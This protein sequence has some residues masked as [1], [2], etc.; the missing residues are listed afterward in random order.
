VL[1]PHPVRA[2][3]AEGREVASHRVRRTIRRSLEHGRARIGLIAGSV[4]ALMAGS[5]TRS[6]AVVPVR[7]QA[8]ATLLRRQPLA[9]GC[10]SVWVASPSATRPRQ[11]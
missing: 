8:G 6:L 3:S 4:S 10:R 11:G 2:R 5:A 1:N 7:V 9:G